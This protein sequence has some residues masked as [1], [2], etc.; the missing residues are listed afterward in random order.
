MNFCLV[1]KSILRR[2]LPGKCVLLVWMVEDSSKNDYYLTGIQ[3][4]FLRIIH[5]FG[6]EH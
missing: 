3:Y 6:G 4:N 1:I 5:I 2:F